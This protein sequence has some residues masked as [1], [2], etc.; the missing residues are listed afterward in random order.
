M[1]FSIKFNWVLQ[2]DLTEKIE[3]GCS[4]P[5]EKNGN[6]V[7]PLDTT[8]DLI[9]SERTAVAKI[10]VTSF[11]NTMNLTSGVFEVLKIYSGEE[12]SVLSNYWM[13]NQ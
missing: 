4:Y 5:F 9:D 8:I 12:K 11:S 7:F 1:G 13:E 2:F 6:R 3:N 10:K